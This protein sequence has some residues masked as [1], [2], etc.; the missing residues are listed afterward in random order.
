M[1]P[2]KDCYWIY[3]EE[4]E[5]PDFTWDSYFENY[6]K[7]NRKIICQYDYEL[8][9]IKKWDNYSLLKQEGYDVGRI[10]RICN[11]DGSTRTH[12]G[13]LWAYDGYDFSDNFFLLTDNKYKKGAHNKRKVNM[14]KEKD[15]E[16]I[17]TFNSM[18]E[19]CIYLEK[20]VKFRNNICQ[21]LS[22][23][24]RSAGYYWEYAD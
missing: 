2:Y 3:K 9:L 23:G 1:T 16:P 11:H 4:Y 13:N 20:P 6:R 24:H 10:L 14:L 21:A 7:S 22:L 5:K 15:G 18:S 17:H 8:N 12:H 19:A